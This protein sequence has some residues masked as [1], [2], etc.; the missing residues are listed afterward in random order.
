M[1]I[2]Q[3]PG[4]SQAIDEVGREKV[5]APVVPPNEPFALCSEKIMIRVS[6]IR[7]TEWVMV[8]FFFNS[9]KVTKMMQNIKQRPR[10]NSHL[11]RETN[12]YYFASLPLQ[13]YF[14]VGLT[15]R[16]S[17]S[18]NEL[19]GGDRFAWYSFE[20][21]GCEPFDSFLR[22]F[23]FFNTFPRSFLRTYQWKS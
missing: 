2:E 14:F 10:K 6:S 15:V 7:S 17:E 5:D 8:F 22:L 16:S 9:R 20:N 18:C 4:Y 23:V 11:E 1:V 21:E 13:I 3:A 19:F 12:R